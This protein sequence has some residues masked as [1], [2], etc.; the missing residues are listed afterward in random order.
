M[1]IRPVTERCA[2][3]AFTVRD[4]WTWLKRGNRRWAAGTPGRAGQDVE[5]R[6]QVAR[7]QAPFAVVL[8]CVDSRVPPEVV[9]DAGLGDLLV[10]RTAAHT[11]DSLVRAAVQYGPHALGAPLVLVLGHQ[12]CGAVTAAATALRERATLP[13]E[14]PAVVAALA[15]AYES[16]GG[17]VAAMTR[18]HTAATVRELRDDPLL[19]GRATV[20]GAHYCLDTGLVSRVV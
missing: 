18:A 14:L 3:R 2:R 9:F 1:S 20:L 4:A 12:R 6:R 17:D 15:G 11:L 5:R 8:S 7:A 10:V 13:G 16:S 19:R